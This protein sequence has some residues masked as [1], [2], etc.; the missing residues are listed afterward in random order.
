M[1]SNTYHVLG[2][3][4]I[5]HFNDIVN[6]K[7]IDTK[8]FDTVGGYLCQKFGYLPSEGEEIKNMGYNFKIINMDERRI[9]KIEVTII[10]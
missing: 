4:E 1:K 6:G 8:T 7:D 3:C 5:E 2:I 9:K 10:E